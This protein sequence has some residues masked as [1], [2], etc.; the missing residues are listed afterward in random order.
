M[1]RAF[2]GIE[3]NPFSNE[4][5]ALL[6][7]QQEIYDTLKVHSQQG[8]LC[9]V[10]GV[11]GTGK[12]VIKEFLK[13]GAGKLVLVAGISRTLHT[14]F[15]TIKI[16]CK[17]FNVDSDGH[18][19]K[20]EKRLIEEAFSLNRQGKTIITV[21]DDAHLMDV[22]TLRK[23]RLLFEEFPKNHNLILF[24]QTELLTNISLNVNQDI[25]SRVTFSAI[26]KKLNPDQMQEFILSEL[27]KVKLGHNTF[28]EDALSLITRSSDGIIRK[29]R[30][31]SVSCFIEAVRR[32]TKII[33]IDTVNSILI[34]PHWRREHDVEHF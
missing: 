34:Q 28:T 7:L 19:F 14:Y 9:L 24:G 33:D 8:G 20:C 18:Y 10:M 4:N 5:I 15:N 22:N 26:L 11:P 16:L 25:K 30:N 1:I 29:A 3:N 12:T 6:P 31:L 32:R 21:I 13:A 2:F 17:S 23:L 27:D